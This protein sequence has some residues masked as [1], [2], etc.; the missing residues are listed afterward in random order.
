MPRAPRGASVRPVTGHPAPDEQAGGDPP[1]VAATQVFLR[2]IGSPL[3]L[4]LL[5]LAGASLVSSGLELG[6]IPMRERPLAGLVILVFTCPLQ[7]L[8]AVFGF[9]GR[10]AVAGTGFGLQAGTWLAVGTVFFT[11]AP[12]STS[13]ALGLLLLCA[14]VG[15]LVPA[16]GAALG[17]LAVTAV[18]AVTAL[19]F[20]MTGVYELSGLQA[21]N[22]AA[23]V[24]GLVLVG[25]AV[26]AALAFELEDAGRRTLLPILRR[27]AGRRSLEAPIGA[28][29]D[30]VEHEAGVREQL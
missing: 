27:G 9:L 4:G 29:V 2:P 19:R 26:Y 15:A 7:L 5:A 10:D 3:P 24:V 20:L 25:L 14:G 17:K 30:R 12:G 22:E 21:F 28:E 11:A 18:F 16:A 23:G 1:K 6:M 13:G 8:A